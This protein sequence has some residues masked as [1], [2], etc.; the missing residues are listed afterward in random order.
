MQVLQKYENHSCQKINKEKSL[1]CMFRHAKRR[2]NDFAELIKKI[3]NNLQIWKSK[4]SA[5]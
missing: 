3:S 4:L 5:L 2:K 1:F